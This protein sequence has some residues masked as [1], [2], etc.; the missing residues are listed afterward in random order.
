MKQSLLITGASGFVGSHLVE[1][2]LSSGYEVWAGMRPS[3]SRRWLTDERIHFIT[4][5][6]DNADRLKEEIHT[7]AASRGGQAWTFVIHAAGA[8]KAPSEAAFMQANHLSTLHLAQTLADLH[9]EPQRFILMSSLS[10]VPMKDGHPCGTIAPTAYG[11]SKYQAEQSLLSILPAS[12]ILRPT[13]VYGPRER[14][15]FLMAKSIKRHFDFAVGFKPQQI[16]FIYVSDLCQAT[17]HALTAGVPGHV[18]QLSDGLTYSSRQFS[19]LLQKEMGI[20]RVIRITAP[21]WLLKAVCYVG[22]WVSNLTHKSSPLNKDKYNILKQ[23]DWQCSIALATK[24]LSFSPTYQLP[25]GVAET[26]AWYKQN[27]WI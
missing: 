16:T 27:K 14:D 10:A 8:T 21:L 17:L 18:Y 11:R 19:L 5:S 15:Y 6:L 2:A 22:Q 7:F 4:L 13:G 1:A 23:R 24:E 26:V 3:S 9:L 25:R 12:V 20:R